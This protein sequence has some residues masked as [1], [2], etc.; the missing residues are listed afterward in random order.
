MHPPPVV[1]PTI[2][3]LLRRR[4][5]WGLLGLE[6][7]AGDLITSLHHFVF[8]WTHSQP[9]PA[10]SEWQRRLV[11][12]WRQ[13]PRSAENLALDPVMEMLGQSLRLDSG[14]SLDGWFSPVLFEL[15]R[16]RVGAEELKPT[17]RDS[18]Q[19]LSLGVQTLRQGLGPFSTE[20]EGALRT[21]L[22]CLQ[23]LQSY[24]QHPDVNY[25]EEAGWRWGQALEEWEQVANL[26]MTGL[27][28]ATAALQWG[29][30][31]EA[32]A[33]DAE[34]AHQ[35]QHSLL[36]WFQDWACDFVYTLAPYQGQIL[37]MEPAVQT[38]GMAMLRWQKLLPGW[39]QEVAPAWSDFQSALPPCPQ[40]IKA[41]HIFRWLEPEGEITREFL[42]Q[43]P[44]RSWLSKATTGPP[45]GTSKKEGERLQ[46][47]LRLGRL[48]TTL[49]QV[50]YQRHG[51]DFPEYQWAHEAGEWLAAWLEGY[52]PLNSALAGLLE[53]RFGQL[54]GLLLRDF[55][56]LDR[57]PGPKIV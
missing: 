37:G 42:L 38:L 48:L 11:Q 16:N 4:L 33:L 13:N 50:Q 20:G 6:Q 27:Q 2:L 41:V 39:Q 29:I 36:I 30:L 17:L 15:A 40:E 7:P 49:V 43:N 53:Q 31:A 14:R 57:T 10:M 24:F 18:W 45:A 22:Q 28:P 35:I 25:L 34:F 44:W 26:C 5:A 52:D 19:R 12:Q 21:F 3:E 54:E 23:Q 51:V 32:M 55:P 1:D 9:P 46:R 8:R 56:V 47:Q